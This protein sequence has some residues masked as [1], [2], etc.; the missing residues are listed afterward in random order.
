MPRWDSGEGEG[1]L[2]FS[3]QVLLM[4]IIMQIQAASGAEAEEVG[5]G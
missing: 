3:N 1:G 4:L 5:Q 2:I